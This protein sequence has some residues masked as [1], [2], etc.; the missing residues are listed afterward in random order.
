MSNKIEVKMSH[1]RSTK[2]T[3][4]YHNEESG[5]SIP[6]LYINKKA[7]TDPPPENIIITVEG[8]DE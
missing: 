8:A 2:N 5:I 7:L 6:A 1:T 3:H 4:V